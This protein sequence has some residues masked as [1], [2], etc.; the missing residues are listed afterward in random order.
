[1]VRNLFFLVAT[2]VLIATA[3][4]AWFCTPHVLWSLLITAP[5]L[6]RGLVDAFQGT[7]TILRNYPVIGHGRYLLETIRP[8]IQQ[9]FIESDTNGTPFSREQRSVVYQRS[10]GVTDTIP[11]G[12]KQNYYGNGHLW[13]EHSMRAQRPMD[14][15]PR[16]LLGEHTCAQ[17]Y[18][19]SLLNISAMS[20]GSLSPTAVRALN[21]A[22][23]DG[24]F[25]HNTGEGGISPYH[26]ENN[27]DLIWQLGTGYFGCRTTD[28]KFDENK[29]RD[30]ARQASVKAIEI[31][32]S[33]GAKP[34]H[35]GILPGAKVNLEIA[36]IR[37]VPEGKDVIS[38]P[39]HNAFQTPMELM[40]FIGR[41]REA[42]GGK[43]IGIKMCMGKPREWFAIVKAMRESDQ[44]PD[45]VAVDGGEGG[46]GAA[47]LEFTNHVGWPLYDALHIVH[48][49]LVGT[50]LRDRMSIIASGH[51][52][53]GFDMAL[54][55]GI[56]ADLCYSARGM[57][58]SLGCIQ[59]L[60][61]NHNACPTGIATQDASLYRGLVVEDKRTRVHHYH[62]NTIRH[63]LELIA[64]AGCSN[65]SEL[66]TDAFRQ[67]T[68]TNEH[69]SL[70][71]AFPR[72]RPGDFQKGHIPKPWEQAWYAASPN[73]F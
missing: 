48:N 66:S 32:I 11:F 60:R 61:C 67:R 16:I 54:R 35:G 56:G 40:Q 27:G 7:H 29:F 47:P 45:F 43:P 36:T 8:E 69:R 4:G 14:T 62:K 72:V 3:A 71:T 17:P 26:L 9:Y 42:S 19:A 10:K 5:I 15:V 37:G 2:V 57:M 28:G 33:Q 51:V 25:A 34:G 31:K 13:L 24:G 23:A 44:H 73:E 55:M 41:L 39:S 1:M 65:P 64:A 53:D 68:G 58:F 50:G 6:G 63:F 21:G 20:F 52:I 49:T 12:T 59:A 30:Q 18:A 22:A 38:P 46:T 70:T